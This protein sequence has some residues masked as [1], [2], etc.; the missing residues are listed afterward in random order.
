MNMKSPKDLID[1]DSIYTSRT[2]TFFGQTIILP[3]VYV[4]NTRSDS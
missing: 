1:I 2:I 4:Q 3:L